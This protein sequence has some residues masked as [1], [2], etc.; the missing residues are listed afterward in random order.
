MNLFI[1]VS[2]AV[3]LLISV[4]Y[5]PLL[6]DLCNYAFHCCHP[7][8]QIRFLWLFLSLLTWYWKPSIR[9]MLADWST[10]KSLTPPVG[11][12][13]DLLVRN[14]TIFTSDSSLP[15]ADSMAI[16][17][18]RIL[19][20]GSF[21]TLKVLHFFYS[22]FQCSMCLTLLHWHEWSWKFD[23]FLFSCNLWFRWKQ[24]FIGDGTMEVNLEG[25]VVVPGLIDSHVH[26]ISGGLQVIMLTYFCVFSFF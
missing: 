13:A 23:T 9:L 12:V 22:L 10:L 3:F 20:V 24:G 7:F 25:K 6:N 16:R 4:A 1:V 5:L 2:A 11:I 19:K 21:A 15:F 8:S 26:L 18:G 14:G 17:N